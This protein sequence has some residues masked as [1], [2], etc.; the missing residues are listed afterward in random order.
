VKDDTKSSI[1]EKLIRQAYLGLSKQRDKV[2]KEA[3]TRPPTSVRMGAI[4]ELGQLYRDTEKLYLEAFREAN[5]EFK[6]AAA[7]VNKQQVEKEILERVKS[8]E[9]A[10]ETMKDCLQTLL[11]FA[12]HSASKEVN[13]RVIALIGPDAPGGPTD[14][15]PEPQNTGAA[16]AVSTR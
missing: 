10:Q 12:Q 14:Q 16:A 7:K 4:A 3:E 13:D 8:L 15:N 11:L 5:D 1:C 6:L 9:T 2:T